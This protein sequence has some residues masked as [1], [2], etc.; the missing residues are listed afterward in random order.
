[1]FLVS[2]LAAQQ[3]DKLAVRY[4]Y[5]IDLKQYPQKTPQDALKSV[6]TAIA[7]QDYHYLIAQLAD[8][9][10]VDGKVN[11][12]AALLTKGKKEAKAFV[13]FQRLV[14]E[15]QAHFL[16]DPEL[17]QELKRFAKDG[18][19]KTDADQTV[20]SLKSLVGRQVFLKLI[21]ERWFIEQRQR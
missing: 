6:I 13:A 12:Y 17:V 1:L 10:Y 4:T 20:V 3:P 9:A 5:E 18:E 8:P 14:K 2:G 15:T 16:E 21:G 11:D 19:F 7:K